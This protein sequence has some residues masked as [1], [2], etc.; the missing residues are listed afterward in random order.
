MKKEI[1]P[2]IMWTIIGVVVVVAALFLIFGAMK[3]QIGPGPE[4]QPKPWRPNYTAPKAA[5][6][7]QGV[8]AAPY[9]G[10]PGSP[11]GAPSAPPSSSK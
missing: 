1:S 4:V 8:Q 11:M 5:G 6:D 9:G 10:P 3:V 7:S 2:A